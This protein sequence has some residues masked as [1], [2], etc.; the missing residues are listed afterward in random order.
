VVLL[1]AVSA[2]VLRDQAIEKVAVGLLFGSFG[3]WGAISG[4]VVWSR[5]RTDWTVALAST[6]AGVAVVALAVAVAVAAAVALAVNVAVAVA[7]GLFWRAGAVPGVIG[8]MIG[9]AMLG[10][11]GGRGFVEGLALVLL[12]FFLVLPLVNGAVD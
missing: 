11:L 6:T 12:I 1:V 8:G 9:L 7:V 4:F 3:V 5:L 10:V 2:A